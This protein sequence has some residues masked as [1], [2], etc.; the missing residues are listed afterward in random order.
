MASPTVAGR[1]SATS[2]SPTLIT[3]PPSR[4]RS[5][6]RAIERWRAARGHLHAAAEELGDGAAA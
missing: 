3:A 4:G 2:S 5:R 6:S 1:A